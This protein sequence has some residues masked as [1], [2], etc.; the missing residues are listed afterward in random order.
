MAKFAAAKARALPA[1]SDCPIL[2]GIVYAEEQLLWVRPFVLSQ[3]KHERPNT[4][5]RKSLEIS[6]S[7]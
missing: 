7:S 3:L 1:V 5:T 6:R 4:I 2:F